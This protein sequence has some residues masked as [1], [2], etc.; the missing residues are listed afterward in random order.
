[1]KEHP[2]YKTWYADDLGLVY[3]NSRLVQGTRTTHGYRQVCIK[4]KSVL[5]HRF[6]YE[7]IN[8]ILLQT[9]QVINHL[10]NN[11]ENNKI[12]NLELT[13]ANGNV[14]WRWGN[15]DRYVIKKP[16]F[17]IRE[18]HQN[19]MAKIT[20]EQAKEIIMLTLSG[21]TNK[22]IASIYNLH[23]RY[24]SLIRHQKRWK[25]V[26]VEL[27]LEGSETIPSGSRHE[28]VSKWCQP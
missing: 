27:G 18:Q 8:N 24:I 10:D 5:V 7:C 9:S 2:K 16:S 12:G 14:G 1:M 23:D 28:A 26:W 13:D 11:G 17:I 22:E 6:V 21:K 19:S 3:H 4:R 25:K 20:R 15:T